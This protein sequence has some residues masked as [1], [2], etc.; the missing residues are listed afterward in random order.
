MTGLHVGLMV[1]FVRYNDDIR[2]AIVVLDHSADTDG[3]VDLDV[4]LDGN[5]DN[6]LASDNMSKANDE[7]MVY[8][9]P[10]SATNAEN[11]WHFIPA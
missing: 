11:S 1:H 2:A 4:E 7:N 6:N 3:V 8:N 9:V 10:Y 5:N